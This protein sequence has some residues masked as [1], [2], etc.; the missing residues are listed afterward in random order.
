MVYALKIVNTQHRIY[1]GGGIKNHKAI[2]RIIET[3]F[4]AFK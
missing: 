4:Y 1:E 3:C 2:V